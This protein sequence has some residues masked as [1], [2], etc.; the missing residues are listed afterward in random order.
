MTDDTDVMVDDI[1]KQLKDSAIECKDLSRPNQEIHLHKEDLEQTVIDNSAELV[2]ASLNILSDIKD[3]AIA[4]GDPEDVRA[5][6]EIMKAT[7]AAAEALNKLHI[8][9]ERNKTSKEMK[10]ADIAS[11]DHRNKQNN[12]TKIMLTREEVMKSLLKDS[13]KAEANN[14]IEAELVEESKTETTPQ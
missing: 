8:S 4:S 14:A 12:E 9:A 13:K 2:K 5:L 7:A 3:R 1:L 10:Q 11:R 6:A